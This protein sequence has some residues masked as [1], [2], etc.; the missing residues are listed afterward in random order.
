MNTAR[1][2]LLSWLILS[3]SGAP[4]IG[5]TGR[6]GEDEGPTEVRIGVF[7]LD[8]DAIDNVNQ[9]F[10]ANVFVM[11]RWRDPSLAHKGKGHISFPLTAVWH[12]R[13]QIVNRQRMWMTFPEVVE[14]SPD[15]EVV[16][17]QRGWGSFSQPLDLREFPFDRQVFWIQ[18]AAAGYT[19]NEVA[20]VPDPELKS[21]IADELSLPDWEIVNFTAE[22]KPYKPRAA[23]EREGVAGFAVSFE[24]KRNH[25]YYVA[26][27][28]VPLVLIV[29][30]SFVV[31][32]IAPKES[33][34]RISVSVTTMLT[35]IAYRFA[36][37]MTL[38]TVSY[39]TRLDYFIL[40]STV[41]I[42]SALLEVVTISTLAR[43]GKFEL[44]R[45]IDFWSRWVFPAVF[46]L[47]AVET[48]VV[49]IWL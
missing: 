24:A 1:A 19:P 38:P 35:L 31:F 10:D 3:V 8:I 5:A 46:V 22:T 15:G 49:G 48:L 11:C 17:R 25:G 13:I 47:V 14:V 21:G 42:F 18:L 44:A 33:A 26:K 9:S 34:T 30:M 6:P 41:L 12:P 32:W 40:L 37:G 7:V 39:L 4:A 28:I 27:V 23:E 36:V 45:R 20:L 43:R 29:A 2:W 16:C